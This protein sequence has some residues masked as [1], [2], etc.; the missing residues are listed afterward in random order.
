MCLDDEG[1][2]TRTL[3][4]KVEFV[5]RP[6]QADA[7]VESHQGWIHVVRCM[8]HRRA[9]GTHSVNRQVLNRPASLQE[10]PQLLLSQVAAIDIQ[11][12]Q[13]AARC[14]LSPK[15]CRNLHTRSNYNSIQVYVLVYEVSGQAPVV[16][17]QCDGVV[18]LEGGELHA[19][20]EVA[21]QG[22]DVGV[23]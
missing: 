1:T 12:S 17:V 19:R 3:F 8:F 13:A 20:C 16:R 7:Q 18:E 23:D 22:N 11:T 21:A 4:Q 14:E 9:P 10:L 2:N 5:P 15:L 6:P